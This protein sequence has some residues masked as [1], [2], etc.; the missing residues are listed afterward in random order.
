[1][2]EKGE[3]RQKRR[4]L[5]GELLDRVGIDEAP[6]FRTPDY[7]Y[8]VSYWLGAMVAASFFYTVITGLILLLLY[9]PANAYGQTEAIINTIPYGSV[10]LFSHLY[11]SYIMIVLVYI[12]MFRNYFKGAYKKP[13]EL[14]WITGILL[15][16]LTLGASFFGYSMV[17]DVLGIDAVDIGASLLIGTGFP[18]ATTIVGW[19]FGPGIDAVQS[20]NPV[21]RSEFFDRILGWHIIMVALIGLL[22]VVHLMLSERYGM[23][24]SVK[25]KPKV[26]AYYTKEEQQR[27]NAWWPR[28]FVY[29]LSILLMTW[30]IILIVPN[31]LVNLNEGTFF[32][33]KVSL[34]LVINPFPAP[35]AFTAAA[36]NTAPYPPWF[37]LFL[38]KFVD[39]LLPNGLPLLPSMVISVMVVGLV[40][41]MLIPFFEN[42]QLMFISSRKFWTWV[43]SMFAYSLVALSIWGYLAPGVPAPFTQ[44]LE[45]LG[46]PAVLI[47]AIIY[48]SGRK[49]GKTL[50]SPTVKAPLIGP[51]SV[52]GT[53]VSILFLAGA[54]GDFLLKPSMAGLLLIPLAGIFAYHFTSRMIKAFGSPSYARV[55]RE[56][57]F[58]AIPVIFIVTVFLLFLMTTLPSVGVASSL[59]GIDLGV[60]VFLWG[61][62]INLYHRVVYSR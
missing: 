24:P 28:N 2:E 49:K 50:E 48:V 47:A 26:P 44:Q 42:S 46:V 57:S 40:V 8:N 30:G 15:L 34:P 19:L 45:I 55:S 6:L 9:E 18:G 27:F 36:T 17:G 62:A 4:G 21:V 54:F 61:Y 25:D 20:S 1:M 7:M 35:Q 37:F 43:M 58:Y 32:G 5:F 41:I 53:S 22:F 31:V 14:Q 29:M 11:G 60:I 23:T 10:L 12:H 56:I 16:A 3:E 39:F 38:Y 51:T 52:L 59:A 33:I 13:R